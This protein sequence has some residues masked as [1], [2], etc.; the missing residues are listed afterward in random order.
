MCG[1]CGVYE[2]GKDNRELVTRMHA[3]IAH[4]GPDSAAVYHSGNVT[5]G[6]RR[7]SIIDLSTGDQPIF[8][9]DR[10]MAIVYNGEI[11][12]FPELRK[13]LMDRGCRFYTQSDTEVILKL[14]ETEGV[15]SFA[16]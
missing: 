5:L 7:L 1:I 15:E 11:Y 4:R 16:R 6:H 13:S 14:Y 9:D 10:S 3:L 8:N 2:S 12:N